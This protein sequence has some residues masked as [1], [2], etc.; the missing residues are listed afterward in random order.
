MTALNSS[1]RR[2]LSLSPGIYRALVLATFVQQSFE[3]LKGADNIGIP[4]RTASGNL[5]E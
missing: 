2:S 5:S 4:A 1:V 3:K